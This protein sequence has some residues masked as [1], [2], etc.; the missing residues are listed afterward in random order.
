M[1]EYKDIDQAFNDAESQVTISTGMIDIVGSTAMKTTQPQAAWL[2]NLGYLYRVATEVLV[3]SVPGVILKYEGDAVLFFCDTDHTTELVNAVIQILERIERSG[4]GPGG[5]Q[6]IDFHCSA[7]ISTGSAVAFRGHSGGPDFVG[8]AV[9]KVF[10]LCGAA[11]G[12]ALFVDTQ[13][14][15]AANT[16][17]FTSTFGKA[18]KQQP[19]Q[20]IGELQRVELKGFPLPE[21]YHEILWDR[22]LHGVKSA[23]VTA[24]AT[25]TAVDVKALPLRV[26]TPRNAE[27]GRALAERHHG[28]LTFWDA[29]RDVGF[30]E[31][32]TGESFFLST[33][34]LV[35]RDD[36]AKLAV[37]TEVAFIATGEVSGKRKRCAGAVLLVGELAEGHLVSLP[38]GKAHGWIRVVDVP[39]NRQLIFAPIAE[40][41]GCTVG[42]LL[43]FKVEANDR[44]AI[45]RDVAKALE[46]VS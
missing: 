26:P 37:G 2:N 45:A 33:R 34:Q 8:P 13:T 22:Q 41:D 35:F 31:S 12:C 14:L 3:A 16:T 44:G 4:M 38:H 30:V 39:G 27:P 36:A 18:V 19:D 46:E 11:S 28:E 20:Y 1:A 40:L 7:A 21:S 10:R 25:R 23:A 9:D 29:D 6:I 42:D 15:G 17:R 32:T 5:E 24:S 43:S